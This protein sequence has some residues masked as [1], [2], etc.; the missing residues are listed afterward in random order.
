MGQPNGT[1]NGTAN[2]TAHKAHENESND[3]PLDDHDRTRS[4]RCTHAEWDKQTSV[5]FENPVADNDLSNGTSTEDSRGDDHDGLEV[6]QPL[7]WDE[8]LGL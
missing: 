7:G 3:L 5:P 1:T 2:G 8:V 6:R 4:D